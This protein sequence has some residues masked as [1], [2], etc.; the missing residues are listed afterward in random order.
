MAVISIRLNKE[1]EKTINFLSSEYGQDKS[2]LVKK[3]I[4]EMYKDYVDTH[5]IEEYEA[6]EKQ[7]KTSFY[8]ADD[9]LSSL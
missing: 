8:S 6:K 7:D 5:C 1:E 2:T 4:R 9:I 3:A